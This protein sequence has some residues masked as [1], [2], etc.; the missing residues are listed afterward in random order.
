VKK[1]KHKSSLEGFTHI[2][3]TEDVPLL[4]KDLEFDVTFSNGSFVPPIK[5]TFFCE[6]ITME[7]WLEEN[8]E[9][10]P[11][12]IPCYFNAELPEG[13]NLKIEPGTMLMDFSHIINEVVNKF[14]EGVSKCK[15]QEDAEKMFKS[16]I[17]L[18]KI[19]NLTNLYERRTLT[20]KTKKSRGK[21]KKR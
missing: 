1:Q 10:T 11:D 18:D 2:V 16:R 5:I 17:H 13:E 7:E 20:E 15:T 21:K 9:D 3:T 6:D 12:E 8:D 19:K 4:K 14:F